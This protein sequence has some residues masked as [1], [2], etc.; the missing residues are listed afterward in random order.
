MAFENLPLS[1][2]ASRRPQ[3]A[4]VFC[5]GWR[6]FVNWPNGL[7]VPVPAMDRDGSPLESDLADGQEVEILSWQPRS[8]R[9]LLYEVRRIGDRSEW[10]LGDAHLR[11]TE[12]PAL[13]PA[14][15]LASVKGREVV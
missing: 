8:R 7:A 5:V 11:T 13:S 2:R 6:A 1:A 12:Q 14:A 3:K 4:A 9:G 10:W 15:A